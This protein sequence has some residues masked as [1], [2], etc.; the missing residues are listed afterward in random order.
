M[1]RHSY[2]SLVS[3]ARM[4]ARRRSYGFLGPVQRKALPQ[5]AVILNGVKDLEQAGS[6]TPFILRV[7]KHQL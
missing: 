4:K 5:C 2:Q 1:R 6:S 3:R 7:S